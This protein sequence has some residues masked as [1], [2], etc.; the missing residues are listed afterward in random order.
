MK[1]SSK[2]HHPLCLQGMLI[3]KITTGISQLCNWRK[4]KNKYLQEN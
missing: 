1:L 2:G 3:N 4:M